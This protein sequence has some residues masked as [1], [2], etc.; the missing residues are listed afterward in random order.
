MFSPVRAVVLVALVCLAL[1][2]CTKSKDEV[3][4]AAEDLLGLRFSQVEPLVS[5]DIVV[6][7]QDASPRIDMAPSFTGQETFS[8]RW[9]IVAACSDQESLVSSGFLEVAVVPLETDSAQSQE[10][11]AQFADAVVCQF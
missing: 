11:F 8:S 7:I 5:D 4:E 6:I 1:G 3:P 9:L 10:Y 2:G